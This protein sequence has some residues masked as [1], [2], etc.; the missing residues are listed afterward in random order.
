[1]MQKLNQ[2]NLNVLKRKT[3]KLCHRNPFIDETTRHYWEKNIQELS[4]EVL[5]FLIR[6]F[7]DSE[8]KFYFLLQ[9]SLSK[10]P[11]E[12]HWKNLLSFKK[13][14]LSFL[15]KTMSSRELEKADEDLSEALKNI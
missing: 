15:L 6:T 5:K 11:S 12:K 9:K 4:R 8:K 10:D 13:K 7:E 1:M 14:Q 3:F 2:T